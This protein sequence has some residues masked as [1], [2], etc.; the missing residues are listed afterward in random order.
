LNTEPNTD[1][2]QFQKLGEKREQE[3]AANAPLT[4]SER[5]Y[6]RLQSLKITP[7]QFQELVD[8][9]LEVQKEQQSAP[10]QTTFNRAFNRAQ[11]RAERSKKHRPM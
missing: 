11:R 5:L 6:M 7:K 8:L 10:K 2:A 3:R 4:A 9:A 1:F